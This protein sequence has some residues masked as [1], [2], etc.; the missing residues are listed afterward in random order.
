MNWEALLS[1]QKLGVDEKEPEEFSRYPM[2]EFEKDYNKIVFSSAFRRLEETSPGM[3][4]AAEG[5]RSGKFRRKCAGTQNFSKGEI[6]FRNQSVCSLHQH[7][8]Q[9]PYRFLFL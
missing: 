4:D 2:N 8:G 5:Q 6:S 9:M 7:S 3:A 1:T